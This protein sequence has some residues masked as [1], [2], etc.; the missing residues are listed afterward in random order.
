[1]SINLT[2][3]S[4]ERRYVA[5]DLLGMENAVCY[6]LHD[7][8]LVWRETSDLAS[9][10]Q[11]NVGR[12]VGNF[13]RD[14]RLGFLTGSAAGLAIFA[15]PGDVRRASVVFTSRERMGG[16][17][18]ADGH[19]TVAPELV[20]EVHSRHERGAT[21]TRRSKRTSRPGCCSSGW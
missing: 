4:P 14:G 20:V 13:V 2:G 16:K 15:N 3:H 17:L 8:N 10:I 1:M 9:W 11:M 21:S 7:G 6:E 19:A 18:P 5:D 12:I